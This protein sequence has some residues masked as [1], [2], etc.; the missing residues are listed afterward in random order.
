VGERQKVGENNKASRNT[1]T[2]AVKWA[3]PN[4]FGPRSCG[5][6]PNGIHIQMAHRTK[7]PTK[8]CGLW[9]PQG[10]KRLDLFFFNSHNSNIYFNF[11]LL[12][13]CIKRVCKKC[14]KEVGQN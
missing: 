13:F 2:R 11:I 9:S 1:R 7:K 10:P 12:Y 6:G 14:I 3:N 4:P 5:S 8:P